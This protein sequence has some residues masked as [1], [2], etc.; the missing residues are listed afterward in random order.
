MFACIVVCLENNVH[1][2][3]GQ[4]VQDERGMVPSIDCFTQD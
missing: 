2:L 3:V 1:F 4:Q